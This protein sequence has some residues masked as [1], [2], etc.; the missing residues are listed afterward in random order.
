MAVGLLLLNVALQ[1]LDTWTTTV[2][3]HAGSAEEVNAFSLFVM[4]Q[5]GLAGWAAMKLVIVAAFAFVLSQVH[6]SDGTTLRRISGPAAVVAVW[7]GV[8]V[9]NNLQVLEHVA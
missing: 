1:V 9:V 3:I 6:G 4:E 8:V 5:W 2:A 7:M